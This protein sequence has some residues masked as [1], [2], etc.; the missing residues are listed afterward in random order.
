MAELTYRAALAAAIAQ[1][2]DRDATVVFIGEDVGAAGGVFKPTP[3]LLGRFGGERVRDTPI[4]E[5]AIL[6]RPW[7][8]R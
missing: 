1:E 8:R 3:G 4:A 6:A 5:Q 2:M 7:A